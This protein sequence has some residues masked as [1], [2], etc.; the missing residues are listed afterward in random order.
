MNLTSPALVRAHLLFAFLSLACG[1]PALR[2]VPGG[3]DLARFQI[4]ATDDGL[5]GAGPIR[6][7]DW[8]KNLW[9]ERRTSFAGDVQRDQGALVFLGD[10]ITQGWGDVGSSFPGIKVANRGISGDTTRGVLI[11]LKEDVLS[12]NPKGV[13]LLIGTNDIEENA[14]PEVIGANVKL[15]VDALKA[16]DPKMPVVLCEIFPSSESMKRPRA[17]IWRTKEL[18]KSLGV[19]EPQVTLLDTWSLFGNALVSLRNHGALPLVG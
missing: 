12:V 2:A 1:A 9:V 14:E 11:R 10:S 4:P 8:F 19:D 6:R 18:Y 3:P 17:K 7:A 13:V 15:I 16:H 5:P